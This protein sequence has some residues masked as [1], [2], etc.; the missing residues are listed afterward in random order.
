MTTRNAEGAID[1]ALRKVIDD[2]TIKPEEKRLLM[3]YM[4]EM[5]KDAEETAGNNG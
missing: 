3:Q 5:R 4:E 1:K 2:E